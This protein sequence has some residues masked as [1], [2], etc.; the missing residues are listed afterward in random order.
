MCTS[1]LVHV[2][3]TYVARNRVWSAEYA[4]MKCMFDEFD[5]EVVDPCPNAKIH[6]IVT[7]LLPIEKARTV[8]PYV[9]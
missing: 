8:C 4:M 1:C 5:G 7:E 3:I 2:V 6:A 9:I